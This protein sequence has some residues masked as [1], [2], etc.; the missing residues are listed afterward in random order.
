MSLKEEVFILNLTMILLGK[1]RII[2]KINGSLCLNPKLLN[3]YIFGEIYFFIL[4]CEDKL[5]KLERKTVLS[6]TDIE[7]GFC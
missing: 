4:K 6:V 7:D 5:G 1:L 2:E 3:K